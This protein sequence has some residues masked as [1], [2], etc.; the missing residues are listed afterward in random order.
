MSETTKEEL[1]AFMRKHG[2]EKVDSITDTESAIRHF[3]C[4]S[5]VYK[6]QRDTLIDDIAVLK[7]NIS[8]LEKRVSELVHENVRLQNDLFT[9]ELNQD[10]ADFVIEKLSKQYTTLTDHI[11]LKAENNPGVSRY[12]DLVNYIDRLE[13]D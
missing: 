5:K 3:R 6:E 2:P 7:A 13:R 8:R 12:I 10:E 4:T 9:E 1:L 11:R